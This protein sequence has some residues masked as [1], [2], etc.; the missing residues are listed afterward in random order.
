MTTPTI[1]RCCVCG[2]EKAEPLTEL[3]DTKSV[4]CTPC[5]DLVL[6]AFVDLMRSNPRFVCE[7]QQA[8]GWGA[9]A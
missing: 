2:Q 6:V 7:R 8:L 4:I 5:V 1:L 9:Q 3:H